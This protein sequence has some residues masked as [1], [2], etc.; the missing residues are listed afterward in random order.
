MHK[1]ITHG[2]RLDTTMLLAK[3]LTAQAL[4]DY[5]DM[6]GEPPL[7]I[8]VNSKCGPFVRDAAKV[9]G[10]PRPVLSARYVLACEHW[11][12]LRPPG[13]RIFSVGN[14]LTDGPVHA[15]L[16]CL[17]KAEVQPAGQ[18]V[19]VSNKHRHRILNYSRFELNVST[20][21]KLGDTGEVLLTFDADTPA[22][23]IWLAKEQVTA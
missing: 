6:Y 14:A 2:K 9:L 5:Q 16:N 20:M 15:I 22:N 4:A 11:L 7:G 13:F 3:E 1:V 18:T 17:A 19:K 8:L 23:E 12:R 21:Y 10:Y